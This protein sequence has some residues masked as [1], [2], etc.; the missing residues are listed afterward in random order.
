MAGVFQILRALFG[1]RIQM[2]EEMGAQIPR[3]GRA[4]FGRLNVVLVHTPELVQDVLIDHAEAETASA[5][6]A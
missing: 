2:V 1:N 4:S 3:I 6:A 5:V